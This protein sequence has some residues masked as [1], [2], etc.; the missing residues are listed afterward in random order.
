VETTDHFTISDVTVVP[1]GNYAYF[2]VSLVGSRAYSAYN[3][4]I[5]FPVGLSVYYSGGKPAVSML[6][7][8]G[9][10]PS[11]EDFVTG[12]TNYSHNFSCTYG[13]AGERMLR[14]GCV[15]SS[16]ESFTANSGILFRVLIVA[17]PFLKPGTASLTFDGQN[18]TTSD[19]T[20]YV[21][22]DQVVTV[23]V[24]TSSTVPISISATN[25]YGTCVVPFDTALPTGLEAFSC[26]SE[27]NGDLML[28]P[29]ESL[30]AYVPYILYAENGFTGNLSGTVDAT[31]YMAV[32]TAGYLNGAVEPQQVSEGYVLQNQG[33]GAK[34]YKIN[35]TT[36]AIPA[37]HCWITVSSSARTL[38]GMSQE[39][40][41]IKAVQAEEA[42][43]AELYSLDG[44]R[45]S[46]PKP[47][48]L[49]ISNGKKLLK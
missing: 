14:I 22:A 12:E 42:T 26:N 1:G 43:E 8:G 4:D 15:S 24:S 28:T 32:V 6:K 35:G 38:L 9:M 7:N 37:G 16:S 48:T 40:T 36:F 13:E 19:E 18:L 31:N 41:A 34:F 49:Y 30:S 25:Q 27:E 46:N 23:N 47:G 44:K 21:P 45:V 29:V 39:T 3:L 20:K 5:H 2:N 10:Y 33:S 11:S 17:S